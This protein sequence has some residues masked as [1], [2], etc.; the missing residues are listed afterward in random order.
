MKECWVCFPVVGELT[1]GSL[2]K[3]RHPWAAFRN[4]F[5]VGVAWSGVAKDEVLTPRGFEVSSVLHPVV[6]STSSLPTLL[7]TLQ[8]RCCG[9]WGNG[10]RCTAYAG[11]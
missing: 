5:G 8:V 2:A 3:A 9:G 1:Q 10:T 11:N 7:S 4:P 6:N